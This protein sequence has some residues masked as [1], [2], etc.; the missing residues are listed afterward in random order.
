MGSLGT[1]CREN[2]ELIT[3][4]YECALT[5]QVLSVPNKSL[6]KSTRTWDTI[7]GGCGYRPDA[8]KCDHTF[9]A[10]W[11]DTPH[12]NDVSTLGIGRADIQPICK[13]SGKKFQTIAFMF[14]ISMLDYKSFRDFKGLQKDIISFETFLIVILPPPVAGL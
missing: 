2:S 14:C 13:V 10:E 12:F 5:L 1:T 8:D 6:N 4:F 7:P 9:C 3:D 11:P